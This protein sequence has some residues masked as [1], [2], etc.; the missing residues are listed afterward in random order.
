MEDEDQRRE[1]HARAFELDPR[2]P[3]AG[4]NFANDLIRVGREGEAMDVFTKI[5]DADPYYPLAY[6]LAGQINEFRGRL[7]EAIRYYKR[8]YELDQRGDTAAKLAT[9]YIDIGDVASADEWIAAAVAH[10]PNEYRSDLEWLKIS[11]LAAR[12]EQAAAR[13]LM[14]PMLEVAAPDVE[15]YLSAAAAGYFLAEP[16]AAIAAWEQAQSISAEDMLKRMHG[17][18]LEA[19]IGAAHAYALLGRET[20]SAALLDRLD[21]WLEEQL[22]NHGRANPGLW[23]VK[24]QVTAIRGEPNLALIHLQRAVDEGWRQHWRP[25]AE[26]CLSELLKLPNFQP[27]M[28]GLAARMDLMREQLAFD[29]SF[30]L[31]S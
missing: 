19:T 18:N 4:Y 21:A 9:L 2:S 12:G 25:A 16:Q 17:Q 27:M 14:R 11:A 10:S 31:S 30:A 20:D 3:V 15:A 13:D 23:F 24:A 29:S 22:E 28:A 7:D 6:E 26:P 5:V 8:V 1:Y